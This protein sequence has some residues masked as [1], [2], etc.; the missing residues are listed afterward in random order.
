MENGEQQ[1]GRR[2][3]LRFI[4]LKGIACIPHGT[5]DT[6]GF[7]K[8]DKTSRVPHKPTLNLSKPS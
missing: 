5:R 8:N 2:R 1:S 6:D 4:L 7:L 3:P